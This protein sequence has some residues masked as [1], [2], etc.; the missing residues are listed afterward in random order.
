MKKK[1]DLIK[2]IR[3]SWLLEIKYPGF[4]QNQIL[5]LVWLL[6]F[7]W[8]TVFSDSGL[9]FPDNFSCSQQN[10]DFYG[11]LKLFFYFFLKFS[12]CYKSYIFLLLTL[13]ILVLLTRLNEFFYCFFSN[14][15]ELIFFAV[16]YNEMAWTSSPILKS[17]LFQTI[18]QTIVCKKMVFW[19]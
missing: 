8:L 10:L 5:C 2:F 15:S 6:C 3:K 7:Y 17:T 12:G 9:F 11:P 1:A 14:G 19:L 4:I 16:N 13:F 18:L